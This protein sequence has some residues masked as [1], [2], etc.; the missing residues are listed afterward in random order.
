VAG[1]ERVVVCAA[2]ALAEGGDGVR[3]ELQRSGETVPAFAIRYGGRVYAYV[4]RCA[5]VGVEL[6]WQPGRFFDADGM[7]LLC[8]T[9]GALYDPATGACRGG[10]CRGGGLIPIAIEEI[11]GAVMLKEQVRSHG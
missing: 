9:H 11:D 10:P 2:G 4:N 3:F 7:V 1:G 8:S 6:D 5:H